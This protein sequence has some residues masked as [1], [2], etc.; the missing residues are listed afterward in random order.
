[1]L[2]RMVERVITRIYGH[3]VM[4]DPLHII[5]QMAYIAFIFLN[6]D[7]RTRA[8]STGYSEVSATGLFVR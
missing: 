2:S 3:A 4:Q 5:L 8:P 6:H 7:S 1:M